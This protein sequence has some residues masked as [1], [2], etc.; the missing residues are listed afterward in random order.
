MDFRGNTSSADAKTPSSEGMI[1]TFSGTSD[2]FSALVDFCADFPVEA[3]D[4]DVSKFTCPK[5]PFKISN[6]EEVSVPKR[7]I[8]ILPKPLHH[9]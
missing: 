4:T 3:D 5:D 8:L 1:E 9:F 6:R 7:A 2:V